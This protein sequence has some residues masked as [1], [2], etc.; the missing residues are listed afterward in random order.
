MCR[1]SY[2]MVKHIF[3][4][5]ELYMHR[6]TCVDA[7]PE[8]YRDGWC[9]TVLCVVMRNSNAHQTAMDYND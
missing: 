6:N 8:Q 1:A 7:K 9:K 2:L 5:S 4:V 3:I